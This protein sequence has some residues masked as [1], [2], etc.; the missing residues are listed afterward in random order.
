MKSKAKYFV[1][2]H[3]VLMV[4]SLTSIASKFASGAD[5]LSMR[6]IVCY[7]LVI[8]GLGIYAIMW[9]QV[10][11]HLPLITAYANKAVTVIWGI[12]WG[13][14]VF[15]EA[16]TVRKIVG[17]IVIVVGVYFIVTADE[18]PMEDNDN[19]AKEEEA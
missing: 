17:A 16:I 18:V 6:F 12:V 10:I 8:A 4:F 1:L 9:Q 3:I 7:G 2:L 19:K 14:L 5:L 11:K 15:D 13:Y